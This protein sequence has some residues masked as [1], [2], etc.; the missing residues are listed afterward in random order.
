MLLK[1]FANINIRKN[2]VMLQNLTYVIDEFD[3][4]NIAKLNNFKNGI[5]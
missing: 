3:F 2:S 4:A 5:S 1:V